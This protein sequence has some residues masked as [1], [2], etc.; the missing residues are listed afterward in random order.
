MTCNDIFSA[1]PGRELFDEADNVN[2]FLNSAVERIAR[3][4]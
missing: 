4:I 2:L 3:L 1:V